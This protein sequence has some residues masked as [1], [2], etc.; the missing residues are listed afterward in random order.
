MLSIQELRS[1]TTKELLQELESARNVSLKIRLSVKTKHEKNS[2][3]K[4]ASKRYIA[5]ILTIMKE[6]AAE[7][8]KK[9]ETKVVEKKSTKKEDVEKKSN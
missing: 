2:S 5:Q 8:A 7:E 1:S 6:I 3:K 4:P 9:S